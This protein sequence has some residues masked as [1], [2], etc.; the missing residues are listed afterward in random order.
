MA[1]LACSSSAALWLLRRITTSCLLSLRFGVS[2]D[3]LLELRSRP[4]STGGGADGGSVRSSRSRARDP[5][6]EPTPR[7]KR[8]LE[9]ERKGAWSVVRDRGGWGVSPSPTPSFSGNA[10]PG[11]DRGRG[12]AGLT[13][14]LRSGGKMAFVS[15]G[16]RGARPPPPAAAHAA[17]RGHSSSFGTT[18]P[19]R[20]DIRRQGGRPPTQAEEGG[21]VPCLKTSAE[22]AARPGRFPVTPQRRGRRLR[23]RGTSRQRVDFRHSARTTLA[24]GGGHRCVIALLPRAVLLIFGLSSL[25]TSPPPPIAWERSRSSLTAFRAGLQGTRTALSRRTRPDPPLRPLRRAS[26][27]SADAVH[28]LA[29]RPLS[30]P[31]APSL[32]SRVVDPD[33]PRPDVETG[34]ATKPTRPS[35]KGPADL[36]QVTKSLP[37]LPPPLVL[38]R[39]RAG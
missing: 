31:A 3:A 11:T 33:P 5:P 24:A 28:R 32:A 19:A 30:A 1:P 7:G 15:R 36:T 37:R 22:G 38:R 2:H 4:R 27:S 34:Q 18:G 20:S 26:R 39:A 23:L 8:H 13:A 10:H 14:V 16:E 21:R 17:A 29:W 6:E 25:A 12:A 35:M 9:G